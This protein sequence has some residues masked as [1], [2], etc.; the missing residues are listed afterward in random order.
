MLCYKR[1]ENKR[2]KVL[3]LRQRRPLKQLERLQ[4]VCLVRA[5]DHLA[6][7][8]GDHLVEH[9]V[10]RLEV[11]HDVELA[12]VAEV[13]IERLDERVDEFERREAVFATNA[14]AFARSSC[15]FSSA[16]SAVTMEASSVDA[17][18]EEERGVAAVDDADAAVV[19]ERA[20]RKREREG[21]FFLVLLSRLRERA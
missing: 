15:S 6:A 7:R 5:L 2:G 21:E 9:V 12:D 1:K 17:D 10:G 13:A 16:C 20:L 11:K 4:H 3:L 14:A 19:D 18:E 8:R